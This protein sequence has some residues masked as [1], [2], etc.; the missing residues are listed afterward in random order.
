MNEEFVQISN[1]ALK[2][3]ETFYNPCNLFG[4]LWMKEFYESLQSQLWHHEK[5]LTFLG[6]LNH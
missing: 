5:P 2:S 4:V 1:I 3:V 6:Q